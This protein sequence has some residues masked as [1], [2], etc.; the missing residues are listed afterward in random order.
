M[1]TGPYAPQSSRGQ[2][3]QAGRPTN[4]P[5]NQRTKPIIQML[6]RT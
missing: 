3:N 6:Y 5:T 1:Q 2:T 4:L